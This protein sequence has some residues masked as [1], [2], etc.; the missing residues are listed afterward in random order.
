M[1]WVVIFPVCV[2]ANGWGRLSTKVRWSARSAQ[3]IYFVFRIHD[4]PPGPLKIWW[5]RPGASLYVGWVCGVSIVANYVKWASG[6]GHD[7]NKL[8]PR[9]F[10]IFI[11]SRHYHI[12]KSFIYSQ[13]KNSQEFFEEP[14]TQ[15]KYLNILFL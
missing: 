14:Y 5:A 13:W 15:Y 9:Y 8:H 3:H 1:V 11:L 2:I 7:K 4:R 6:S 12:K 10:Y